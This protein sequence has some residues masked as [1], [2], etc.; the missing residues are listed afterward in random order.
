MA[1]R[2]TRSEIQARRE[3]RLLN[4]DDWQDLGES[5]VFH[6]S[7]EAPAS[8]A[9]AHEL[10][11]NQEWTTGK[12][13]SLV[14]NGVE[15]LSVDHE[16]RLSTNSVRVTVNSE[17]LTG[18]VTLEVTD[19]SHQ[20]LDP[21]AAS[22]DVTLPDATE[23]DAGIAFAFKNKSAT[24][25]LVIKDFGGDTIITIGP[26]LSATLIFDGTEWEDL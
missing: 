21:G 7:D 2:V 5:A 19:A 17:T 8:D 20:L 15:K 18:N 13:F 25:N 3:G 4:L 24:Y 11:T 1:D 23:D 6:I 22:R 16:G 26:E 10:S 12:L 14:N 9:A